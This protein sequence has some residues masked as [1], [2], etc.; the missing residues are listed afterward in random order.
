MDKNE[1]IRRTG[2]DGDE[3]LLLARVLDK[4]LECERKGIQTCTVFL[5]ERERILAERLAALSGGAS[6]VT[7]GG[8]EGA[9]R[10]AMI[11]LP[12]WLDEYSYEPPFAF[13]RAAFPAEHAL[14]HRD[15]LGALMA[16]GIKRETVGD[17][18]VTAGSCDM[19]ILREILPYVMQNLESAGRARLSLEEISADRLHVPEKKYKIIKDTVASPRLDSIVASGFSLSRG[20]ASELIKSG[21]VSLDFTEC[22]K[23]D[24]EVREGA[25]ISA[26]GFGRLECAAIGGLSRKGRVIVELRLLV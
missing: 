18:L 20:R 21:R 24:A 26:R 15:F 5:S 14:S 4:Q 8:Y 10:R 12:E 22:A 2:A 11:F 9:E 1:L 16:L 23:P 7:D 6:H 13:V 25:V 3:K 19:V 17:L